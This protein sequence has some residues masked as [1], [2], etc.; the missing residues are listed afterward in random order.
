MRTKVNPRPAFAAGALTVAIGIPAVA[1]GAGTSQAQSATVIRVNRTHLRY[2]DLVTVTGTASTSGAGQRLALEFAPPGAGW[3]P[4]AS[5]TA[6][7]DGSFRLRTRLYRS[8]LLRVAAPPSATTA[9]GLTP[10]SASAVQPSVS[11]RVIVRA[12]LEVGAVPRN[13]LGTGPIAV[14]GRLLPGIPGRSVALQVSSGAAWQTVARGHTRADGRLVLRFTPSGLGSERLRVRFAGDSVSAH[15]DAPA[16]LLTV[17][18]QTVASWYNDGGST[19]CGFHAGMGVANKTLPCGTKVTFMYGGRRV[20]AVVDDRGPF[21]AGR[22]WD[23]NQNTAAA[24]GV[25]GVAT[26]W[27]SA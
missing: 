10:A 8:G 25:G 1:L 22:T 2:G 20:T 19:A 26:V 21:V 16:G 18:Q 13:V 11:Q 4:V 5:T 6:G 24:L 17:Y 23:L 9:A 7:S 14:G 27:S 12:R 15:T 3:T